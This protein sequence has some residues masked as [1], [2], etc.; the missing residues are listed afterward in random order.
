[1]NRLTLNKQNLGT[2]ELSKSLKLDIK[3]KNK[4]NKIWIK[5]FL[6]L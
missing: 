5:S 1:M 4:E 3:K 2:L 6:L